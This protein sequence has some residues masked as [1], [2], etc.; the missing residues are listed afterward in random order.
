MSERQGS[1]YD[2]LKTGI[3]YS[4]RQGSSYDALKTGIKYVREAG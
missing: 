4:E 3:K 1:Y 2:A